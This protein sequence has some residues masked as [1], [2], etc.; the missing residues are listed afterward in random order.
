MPAN[1]SF[2]AKSRTRSSKILPIRSL[3]GIEF[4]AL[5]T[6]LSL[7]Y[8]KSAEL[9]ILSYV[10][11]FYFR[12]WM[13]TAHSKSESKIACKLNLTTIWDLIIYGA[14]RFTYLIGEICLSMGCHLIFIETLSKDSE[15]SHA[16]GNASINILLPKAS[17]LL[18]S[19]GDR[20]LWL[21]PTRGRGRGGVGRD[22]VW[23]RETMFSQLAKRSP[24][25][26]VSG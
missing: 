15:T 14:T 11:L 26:M 3:S 2:R 25:V 13:R 1:P 19:D 5:G 7:Q 8:I 9:E 12:F 21:V 20:E 6:D 16:G 17:I 24:C 23:D 22:E 18:V 4:T 10:W